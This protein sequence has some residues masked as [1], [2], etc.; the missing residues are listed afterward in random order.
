[1]TEQQHTDALMSPARL[2]SGIGTRQPYDEVV[3]IPINN[4]NGFTNSV[5]LGTFLQNHSTVLYGRGKVDLFRLEAEVTCS[6]KNQEYVVAI[7]G[8][9]KEFT[10]ISAKAIPGALKGISNSFNYGQVIHDELV[11][12]DLYSRQIQPTSGVAMPFKL[13]IHVSKGVSVN[14]HIY[15]KYETAKHTILDGVDFP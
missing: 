3:S 4:A 5:L 15:L 14:L 2:E 6:D 12:S 10:K 1:M 8:G 11:V 7:V 13:F 9:Y